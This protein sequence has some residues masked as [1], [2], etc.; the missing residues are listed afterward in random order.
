MAI[1]VYRYDH[2][3]IRPSEDASVWGPGRAGFAGHWP[4]FKKL[5]AILR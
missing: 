2:S 5:T 4:F 3:L 1:I